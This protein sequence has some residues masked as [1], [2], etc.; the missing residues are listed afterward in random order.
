MIPPTPAASYLEE[1]FVINSTDFML[2]A[3]NWERMLSVS[4]EDK[5]EGLP[6][7]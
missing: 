2:F 1:G 5:F 6:L 3:G 4:E 7:I